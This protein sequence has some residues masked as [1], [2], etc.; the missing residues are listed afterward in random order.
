MPMNMNM[1]MNR[2]SLP[3]L[4]L[5]AVQPKKKHG[6]SHSRNLSLSLPLPGPISTSQHSPG[7]SPHSPSPSPTPT[8]P[9]F[10]NKRNSHH[11]RLS[12][13]STRNESA[14]IM[15][16]SLPDLPVSA[17][18]DPTKDSIR[19]R[20]LL[21]LEGRPDS[22]KEVEIPMLPS[23]E[24]FEFRECLSPSHGVTLIINFPF[25][26]HKALIPRWFRSW[27]WWRL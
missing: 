7:P 20:A 24:S 10:P 16:V 25:C 15:G 5:S 3:P 21:A 17:D 8:T 26:S 13:V 27:L 11:R 4:P 22:Y 18:M 2:Q 19:R 1:N 9:G 12:S 6:R 14:E 23:D